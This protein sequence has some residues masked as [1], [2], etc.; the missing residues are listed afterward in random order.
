MSL[1]LSEEA[2]KMAASNVKVG[3]IVRPLLAFEAERGATNAVAV[4][5]KAKVALSGSNQVFEYDRAFSGTQSS[6]RQIYDALVAPLLDGLF[7]GFSA[8][9]FA[10][11]Q[12]GSGKTHTMGTGG[13]DTEGIVPCAVR[14]LFDRK[15]AVEAAG[16]VASLD[17]SYLEIYK[18]ECFDLLVGV[19]GDGGPGGPGS[20]TRLEMRDNTRGE[21]VVEGLCSVTV[22]CESDVHRLLELAAHARS[23][24]KTNM[25]ARSSRSHAIATFH[26]KVVS[27]DGDATV[28]LLSKLHL[29][30]LAGSERVKKT[31]AA[32]DTLAEGMSPPPPLQYTRTRTHSPI[33]PYPLTPTPALLFFALM[34][35]VLTF[36]PVLT[37]LCPPKASPSTSPSSRWA[38][39]WPHSR[40]PRP[41]AT[42]RTTCR[43][44]SRSSRAC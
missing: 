37:F 19:V 10:Y 12:T 35:H 43:T 1:Q 34:H 36:R 8:T 33:L 2:S 39:S 20:R 30:D 15:A 7:E 24:G 28:T 22:A 21:T 42:P 40:S 25:N 6:A 31:Q 17:M 3:V 26:L 23:T 9:V 4:Q 44:G 32:G 14:S 41:T 13:G 5:G 38:T 27:G 16:A 18:E 29:V 11:G